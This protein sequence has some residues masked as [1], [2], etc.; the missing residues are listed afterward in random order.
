MTAGEGEQLHSQQ[1]ATRRGYRS[2]VGIRFVDFDVISG[3]QHLHRETSDQPGETDA[4][5]LTLQP[6]IRRSAAQVIHHGRLASDNS[7]KHATRAPSEGRTC[8]VTLLLASSVTFH[9]TSTVP[10]ITTSLSL[11]T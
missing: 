9:P 6:A 8:N 2:I 7:L 4:A 3:A 10:A 11:T 1:R 5:N